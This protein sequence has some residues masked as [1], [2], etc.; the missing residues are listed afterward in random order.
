L[1]EKSGGAGQGSFVVFEGGEGSGKS[2]QARRLAERRREVHDVMLT[3]EP[4]GTPVGVRMREILL[5]PDSDDVHPRAEALLMAAD[6]AH[7]VATKIGPALASGRD[8]I[9]DRFMASSMAYQGA[10]RGLGEELVRDISL[11]AVDGL[12]PDLTILVD[13]PV[14][15]GRERAGH[16]GALDK[17]EQEQD[18][19]HET[20]RAAFLSFA[21]SDDS[22]VIVDGTLSEDEVATLID[23]AVAEKLG[24]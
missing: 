21:E 9:S 4:G 15:I 7:H 23:K 10:A 20:V 1:S 19:F 16:R 5:D 24:W 14:A 8:V 18:D 13:V 2:T 11:F 12:T 17:L 6:R 3:R 22:W